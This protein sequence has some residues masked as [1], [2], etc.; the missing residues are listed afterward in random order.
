MSA[1]RPTAAQRAEAIVALVALATA[2]A[3]AAVG[4]ASDLGPI[5]AGIA[6]MA[7]LGLAGWYAVSRAGWARTVAVLVLVLAL[8]AFLATVLASDVVWWRVA[9][10]LAAV[11][12]SVGAARLALHPRSRSD[13]LSVAEPAPAPTRPVL[14]MNPRSG[15]GKVERF[16]LVDE[17]RRRGIEPI[18]LRPGDDLAAL[19]RD[20]IARGAD[21]VGMAGGD[22]SQALVAGLASGH[23][24]PMVVIPAGTRNHF[25]LDIGVDRLDVVGALDAFVHGLERRVDLATVNGR[26]FVNNAS[27]GLYARIV[28]SP[29]YRDAKLQTSAAMLPEMLGPAAADFDLRFT[30][31]DGAERGNAQLIMVSNNPYRL[32][33]LAGLGTREHLDGGVLGIATARI[34]SAAEWERL[35]VL[36]AAGH[37]DRFPGLLQWTARE[38]EI[39]SSRPAE[40]GVDGEALVMDPPLEFRS[41]PAALRLRLPPRAPGPPAVHRPTV[42]LFAGSTVADLARL[43]GGRPAHVDR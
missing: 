36:Q 26:V 8:A 30:D 27:L 41:M 29:E 13:W 20:A 22:G 32:E 14:L 3:I 25:A 34:G 18:V 2:L 12:I 35:L 5:L 16:H 19:T 37:M 15:G 21:V 42:R 9:A 17:C 24:V 4:V 23:N 40:I 11:G 7:V 33:S 1:G 39:R 6:C 10:A 43:A 28:Q 31:P 38:F